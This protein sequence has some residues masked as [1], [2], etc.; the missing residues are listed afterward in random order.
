[1]GLYDIPAFVDF[2]LKTTEGKNK[3]GKLAAYIGHSEGTTQF[4]I[5]SS[6]KPDFYKEK[7]NLFVALAPIVRLDHATNKLMTTAAPLYK[8]IEPLVKVSGFYSLFDQGKFTKL[9][10]SHVCKVIPHFC[11]ALGE[12][13]FDFDGKIDNAARWADKLAHNPAGAGWR[14]IAHYAQIISNKRFQRYD[15]GSKKNMKKYGQAMA[16][17]YDLSK[18]SVPIAIAHGDV[19][20]LG[21]L[22]DIAWLVDESKSDLRTKDLL[23]Q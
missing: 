9:L 8:I 22:K 23:L 12:G 13:F 20:Q 1:M 11:E 17:D 15:F 7:V 4:F 10:E 21:D 3:I 16:P 5:G 14:N 18:I 6:L 2:I 19:D